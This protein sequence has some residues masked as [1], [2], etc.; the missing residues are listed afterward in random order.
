MDFFYTTLNPLH[1]ILC[2]FYY[3]PPIEFEGLESCAADFFSKFN[4]FLDFFS[5]FNMLGIYYMSA[6]Y[7]TNHLWTGK[8]HVVL[9]GVFYV[10]MPV[11]EKKI[12]SA[13]SSVRGHLK[14]QK[15]KEGGGGARSICNLIGL[16]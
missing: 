3:V 7:P 10:T 2:F 4:G 16:F 14:P 15:I 13:M 8:D 12:I 1:S 11:F 5:K 6:K 9:V